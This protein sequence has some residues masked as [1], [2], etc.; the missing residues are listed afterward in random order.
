[1]SLKFYS[2]VQTA[3]LDLSVPVKRQVSM[4]IQT[5]LTDESPA[6]IEQEDI[7]S[8]V[9]GLNPV[10]VN[11]NA[12]GELSSN[13]NGNR[14]HEG[15]S[16]RSSAS[17]SSLPSHGII[18]ELKASPRWASRDNFYDNPKTIW[19]GSQ[20]QGYRPRLAYIRGFSQ[21]DSGQP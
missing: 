21:I 15:V 17:S 11:S 3:Q 19:R 13:R 14:V 16:E 4:I 5:S 9:T 10:T 8:H 6:F 18:Q 12:E 2:K 1:M 20:R 7:L